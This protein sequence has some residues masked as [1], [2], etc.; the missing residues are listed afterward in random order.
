M[1]TY[2]NTKIV[3]IIPIIFTILFIVGIIIMSIYLR[4]NSIG[5]ILWGI[6][7]PILLLVITI[8]YIVRLIIAPNTKLQID[9]TNIYVMDHPIPLKKIKS[10]THTTDVFINAKLKIE[11]LDNEIYYIY[12]LYDVVGVERDINKS[13]LKRKIK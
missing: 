7:L 6:S 9:S 12:K 13:F 3:Y 1:K 4:K 2:R 11:T 10:V 8:I 5:T